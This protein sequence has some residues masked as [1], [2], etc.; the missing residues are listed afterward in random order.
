LLLTL[1]G[2]SRRRAAVLYGAAGG[3]RLIKYIPFPV[4]SVT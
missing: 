1:V 4:V 2:L 3:G